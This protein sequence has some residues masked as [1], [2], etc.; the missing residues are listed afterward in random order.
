MTLADQDSATLAQEENP[1]SISLFSSVFRMHIII[2]YEEIL[3]TCEYLLQ[4]VQGDKGRRGAR[5]S[6]GD[7]GQ[8][9]E[10]GQNGVPGDPV[11]KPSS[12]RFL[13]LQCSGHQRLTSRIISNGG[14]VRGC[15]KNKDVLMF[16]ML[17][18]AWT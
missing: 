15:V 11:S 17:G 18:R 10:P 7:C 9:G 8:K 16:F 3:A 2:L 14:L 6:R 13:F 1:Y 5:G 4:G 12:P